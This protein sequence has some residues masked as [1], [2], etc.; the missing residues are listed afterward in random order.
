MP[1]V[2]ASGSKRESGL[3]RIA[4]HGSA[5]KYTGIRNSAPNRPS[6]VT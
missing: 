4:P 5:C 2:I 3:E 1:D 6:T